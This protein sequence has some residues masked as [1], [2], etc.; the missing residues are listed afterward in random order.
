LDSALLRPGRIDM[1]IEFK[2]LRHTHIAEIFKK[3]Y[4]DNIPYED[5]R[6]IPDYKYTQAEISQLLFKY[7]NNSTGFINEI[8]K[9]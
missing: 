9:Y 8:T 5:I 6:N 3:W 7:E 1:E 2:R 4:D